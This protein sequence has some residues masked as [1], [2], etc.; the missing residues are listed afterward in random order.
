[1]VTLVNTFITTTN[2]SGRVKVIN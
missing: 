1:M 2:D